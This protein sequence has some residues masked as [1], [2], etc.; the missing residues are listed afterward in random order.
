MK[1]E[2]ERMQNCTEK[3]KGKNSSSAKVSYFIG[4]V[5]RHSFFAASFRFYTLDGH[6]G[7]FTSKNV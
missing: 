3:V 2:R 5:L 6:L 7:H 4:R 1:G